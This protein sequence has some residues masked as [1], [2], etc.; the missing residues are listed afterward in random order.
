LLRL[1]HK[2]WNL[3]ILKPLN[4][5]ISMC[6]QYAAHAHSTD[7][8]VEAH[9]QTSELHQHCPAQQQRALIAQCHRQRMEMAV[10]GECVPAVSNNKQRQTCVTGCFRG[11]GT[12][13][14]VA[15]CQLLGF[16]ERGSYNAAE[17]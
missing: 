16:Q 8:I 6:K 1:T 13:R 9:T 11:Q 17:L 7:T 14:R 4:L 15:A 12:C 2:P 5:V 3:P 10:A